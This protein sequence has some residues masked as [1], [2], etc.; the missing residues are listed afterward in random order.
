MQFSRATTVASVLK[1]EDE[2]ELTNKTPLHNRN[3]KQTKT[4]SVQ[5]APTAM[6]AHIF[7]DI[8]IIIVG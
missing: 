2:E 8:N 6:L 7:I 3:T 4:E 1:M 5:C